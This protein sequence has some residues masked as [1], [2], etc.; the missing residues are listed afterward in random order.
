[1]DDGTGTSSSGPAGPGGPA[2]ARVAA[3]T[4]SDSAADKGSIVGQQPSCL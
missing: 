2:L 1:V 3:R 4:V